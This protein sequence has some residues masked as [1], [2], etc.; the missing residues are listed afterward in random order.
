MTVLMAEEAKEDGTMLVRAPE[1]HF[2]LAYCTVAAFLPA[3]K[4]NGQTTT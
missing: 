2:F 4:I 3:E 1:L